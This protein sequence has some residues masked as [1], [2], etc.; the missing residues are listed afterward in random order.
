MQLF[1]GTGNASKLRNMRSLLAGM[2]IELLSPAELG[3]SLPNVEE[4]GTTPLENARL[5]ARAYYRET[6]IPSFALD[7]GLYLEGVPSGQQ[8]GPYV[9]R[10]H[11]R[12][13]SDD[14]F[15]SYYE[16]L[17]HEHHGKLKARFVN[18]LCVVLDDAHRKEAS[19]LQVS[20]DWFWI[21]ENAHEIR[22]DGFPMDS[23]AV[24]PQTGLYWVENDLNDEK[25]AKGKTLAVGVRKFFAELLEGDLTPSVEPISW[26]E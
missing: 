13:L 23:I 22:L 20:T 25:A 11:G 12:E 26:R 6:G 1:Y 3:I 24:D 15:I 17:A 8:P 4:T 5:K 7:S 16:Q 21:V 9:R 2:P 14:E 19:G 10:V 18:G